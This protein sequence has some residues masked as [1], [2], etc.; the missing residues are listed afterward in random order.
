MTTDRSLESTILPPA[1]AEDGVDVFGAEAAA[2]LLAEQLDETRGRAV[3]P[4]PDGS[5]LWPGFAP[6][7]DRIEGPGYARVTLVVFGAFG[8]PSSRQLGAVLASVRERHA[9][10]L[11]VAW[12]HLP[13]PHAHPR[14]AILALAAEAA[15]AEGRFWALTHELLRL[16]HD[17]P[18]DL[19]AALLRAGLDPE[20]TIDA[21]RAGTGSDRIVDDV[22]SALGSGVSTAPALFVNDE[23]YRGGLDPGGVSA[24]L[25]SIS[26]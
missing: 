5:R 7:R 22:T 6:T 20:R 24:A 1:D 19:H 9:G 25:D 10:R 13:D 11:A 17:D 23:R 16:R 21:M 8:A 18:R 14:T 26:T 2:L 4:A 12:R 15:H 3:S